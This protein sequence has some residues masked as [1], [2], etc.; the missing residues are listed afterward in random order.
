MSHEI[1]FTE[2]ETLHGLSF[3]VL[4]IADGGID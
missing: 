3:P 2:H 1:L 4:F